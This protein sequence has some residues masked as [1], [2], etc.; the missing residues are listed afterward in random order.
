MRCFLVPKGIKVDSVQD[1][2]VLQYPNDVLP[3][4]QLDGLPGAPSDQI[5]QRTKGRSNSLPEPLSALDYIPTS[6]L[7]IYEPIPL[8]IKNYFDDELPRELRLRVFRSLLD[9]HE[10]D[11]Q[12]LVTSGKW[13][14]SKA[15][16][17]RGQWVGKAKGIR[18]L[19]KLSRVNGTRFMR[20]FIL[21]FVP[22]YLNHG[23]D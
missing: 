19:F 15:S 18:E 10:L 22:R 17:S 11:F 2:L 7:D 13:S 21:T 8:V 6:S 23:K 14:M 4:V 1:P 9:L 20:P 3:R 16:S 12:R 5:F